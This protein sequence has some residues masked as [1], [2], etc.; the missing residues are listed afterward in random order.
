MKENLSK[1]IKIIALGLLITVAHLKINGFDL[2][3]DWVGYLL[4]LIGLMP[5][6]KE[7]KYSSAIK[8]LGIVATA[9]SLISWVCAF[10]GISLDNVIVSMIFT[11]VYVAYYF[12]FI[13]AVAFCSKEENRQ[14]RIRL[15][16]I[17]NAVLH[18]VT[19]VIVFIP[20]L[21]MVSVVLGFGNLAVR[22]WICVEIFL[23]SS[24]VKKEEECT[25]AEEEQHN[26]DG[27]PPTMIPDP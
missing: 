2:L 19:T 23:L 8:A 20:P 13:T 24:A 1:S 5:V 3:I 6:I 14:N 15:S 16:A 26:D 17:I 11:A 12:L 10:T 7:S 9:W 18:I 27:L 22:I 21:Q 4:I 25:L